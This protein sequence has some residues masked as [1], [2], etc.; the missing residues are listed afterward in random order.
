M[1]KLLGITVGLKTGPGQWSGTDDHI[2]VGIQG[3]GGGREFPLDVA[4]FDD[5]E[6]G[7][8]VIYLLGQVWVSGVSGKKEKKP[9]ESSQG[10]WN[11]PGKWDIDFDKIDYVYIRKGGTRAAKDDDLYE[12]DEIEVAIYGT[13]PQSRIFKHKG[14]IRLANEYGLQIWLPEITS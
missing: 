11:D 1:S 6:A 9:F 3:K 8:Y 4:G 14:Y 10:G 13:Q 7:T 2:Y 5:F 12:M